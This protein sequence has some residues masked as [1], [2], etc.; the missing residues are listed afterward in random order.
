MVDIDFCTAQ[1]GL[2]IAWSNVTNKLQ[3]LFLFFFRYLCVLYNI[4]YIFL[5]RRSSEQ[6]RPGDVG[7]RVVTTL[8]R[9]IPEARKPP[10]RSRATITEAWVRVTDAAAHQPHPSCLLSIGFGLMDACMASAGTTK[11]QTNGPPLY[12][13]QAYHESIC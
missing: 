7:N 11:P 6:P 9:A 4:V 8:A 12:D 10:T 2:S 3:D 1:S 5:Q 13:M